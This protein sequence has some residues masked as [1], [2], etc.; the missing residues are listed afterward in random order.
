MT[1]STSQVNEQFASLRD[2]QAADF[3]VFRDIAADQLRQIL[4][5]KDAFACLSIRPHVGDYPPRHALQVGML[6]ISIGLA[7]GWDEL[8]LAELR[9]GCLI[10]DA[11]MLRLDTPRYEKKAILSAGD[12]GEIAEHTV[13]G[14]EAWGGLTDEVSE[15]SLIVAYQIHER[16]NGTGYPRGYSR[17][18]IHPMARVAGLADVFV[19]LVS[20]RP[21]R[22]GMVPYHAIKKIIQD[23]GRGLFDREAVSALLDTVSIF[24]VG[25]FVALNDGRVGRVIRPNA[26]RHDR[27]IIEV[28]QR[29]KLAQPPGI[30][31]LSE[32]TDITIA[33]SLARLDD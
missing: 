26:G 14:L 11:G 8:T 29:G 30:V 33:S 7:M 16:C 17:D 21:H 31:D 32:E 9:I 22:P 28:W 5:D 6:A 25:S 2:G 20:P 19:A 18:Q 15:R 27:P 13:I 12:V 10:H 4:E 3:Q 23:T 1:Q 24:P